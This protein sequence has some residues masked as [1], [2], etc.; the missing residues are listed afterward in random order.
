MTDIRGRLQTPASRGEVERAWGEHFHRLGLSSRPVVWPAGPDALELSPLASARRGWP[1]SPDEKDR[2]WAR[3]CHGASLRARAIAER[4]RRKRVYD[5]AEVRA[6]ED[7]QN[8]FTNDPS[9]WAVQAWFGN[10]PYT[11]SR[12]ALRDAMRAAV[13]ERILGINN[14][15]F[16]P[17]VTVWSG[18][19][20]AWVSPA[21]VLC[22]E[23]PRTRF[24]RNGRLH[25]EH[26]PAVMWNGEHHYFWHG[27]RVPV[28]VILAPDSLQLQDVVMEKN[29][30]VR[31][32]MLERVGRDRLASHGVALHREGGRVLR[33]VPIGNREALVFLEVSCPSTGRVYHLQVPPT[34][35]TCGE[36][37]AWTF[38]FRR[39]HDY[40]PIVE[41]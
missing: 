22:L 11:R 9:A 38:G 41:T 26:G 27:V 15:P 13:W 24:D 29:A 25:A 6:E 28:N 1:V 8:V 10:A 12:G 16:L 33:C 2:D 40:A 20:V 30:E 36:A 31:R 3:A 7:V 18:V 4:G 39:A 32:V 19:A 5:L 37:V 35:Q 34:M 21:R 17:L 14:N 23:P